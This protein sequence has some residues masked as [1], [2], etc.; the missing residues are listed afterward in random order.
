M[1][2]HWFCKNKGAQGSRWAVFFESVLAG[3][4]S[5]SPLFIG[6]SSHLFPWFVCQ[7]ISPLSQF[8]YLLA[9]ASSKRVGSGCFLQAPVT[10]Y[11]SW[12][13]AAEHT[14][15]QMFTGLAIKSLSVFL[16]SNFFIPVFCF[17]TL[18]LIILPLCC[19][20][21]PSGP[22]QASS[23]SLGLSP[24]S[25]SSKYLQDP[26]THLWTTQ[27]RRALYLWSTACSPALCRLSSEH[28]CLSSAGAHLISISSVHMCRLSCMYLK[29]GVL[30][31]GVWGFTA[32]RR[33]LWINVKRGWM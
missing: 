30:S 12:D 28:N 21:V 32:L 20:W 19:S 11:Q 9:W 13:G 5:D 10:R 31:P 4:H 17:H 7:K 1:N 14:F 6:I 8:K 29:L 22:L 16:R 15:L 3:N 2:G 25:L 23:T 27:A 33:P 24:P 18:P 26:H